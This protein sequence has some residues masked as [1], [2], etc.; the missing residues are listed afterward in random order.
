M[1]IGEIATTLKVNLSAI[2]KAMKRMRDIWRA[3]L[4]VGA[5]AVKSEQLAKLD[6]MEAE[7][8]SAW[9]RSK[10]EAEER[11]REKNF[12]Q[13]NGAGS[14]NSKKTFNRDGDPRYLDI[15]L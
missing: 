11:I 9:Q 4:E 8:W 6:K 5:E 2:S 12:N 3:K 14:K 13:K 10:R 15:V 7:A 1:P